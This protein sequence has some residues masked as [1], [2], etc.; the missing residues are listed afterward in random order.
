MRRG[1]NVA[2]VTGGGQCQ[3]FLSDWLGLELLA[4]RMQHLSQIHAQCTVIGSGFSWGV[5]P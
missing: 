4:S 1:E 2:L 5:S 3:Q